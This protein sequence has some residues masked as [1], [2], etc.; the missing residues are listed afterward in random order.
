MKRIL[1]DGNKL[2]EALI[3]ASDLVELLYIMSDAAENGAS[4]HNWGAAFS[5]LANKQR[6]IISLLDDAY[7]LPQG[8]QSQ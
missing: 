3:E 4:E 1:I 8:G 7:P 2:S 6:S 5:M